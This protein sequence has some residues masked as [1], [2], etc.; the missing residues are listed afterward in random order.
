MAGSAGI[1]GIHFCPERYEGTVCEE[2][3]DIGVRIREAAVSLP[4]IPAIPAIP[5][6]AARVKGCA[7]LG[8]TRVD[9]RQREKR[10]PASVHVRELGAAA[11]N[12]ARR[13]PGR[14]RGKAAF[15]DAASDYSGGPISERADSAADLPAAK[16]GQA[17]M[18]R[19]GHREHSHR[20]SPPARRR[21][22]AR[23][24]A[25]L[26]RRWALTVYCRPYNGARRGAWNGPSTRSAGPDS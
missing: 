24:A 19:R 14:E 1:A 18:R 23:S 11:V 15:S 17:G 8:G 12:P 9:A 21:R 22:C 20:E 3:G 2:K 7:A 5:A 13:A 25:C 16:V 4:A 26:R 6:N 10:P